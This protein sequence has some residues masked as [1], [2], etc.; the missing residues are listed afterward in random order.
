MN[1]MIG[2]GNQEGEVKKS[3]LEIYALSLCFV[4]IVCAAISLGIGIYSMVEIYKPEFTMFSYQY[5]GHQTNELFLK[6]QGYKIKTPDLSEEEKTEMRLESYKVALNSEARSGTQRLVKVV[7]IIA[8]DII[9]FIIH[10]IIAMRARE[11]NY[12]AG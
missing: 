8:I 12:V 5:E 1:K 10:W 9:V 2:G 11:A 6:Q 4:T 7:I 3:K